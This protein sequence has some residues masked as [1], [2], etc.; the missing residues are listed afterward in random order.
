[1]QHASTRAEHSQTRRRAS[2][3]KTADGRRR[4]IRRWRSGGGARDRRAGASRA[5]DRVLYGVRAGR[6]TCTTSA[7]KIT[8]M[9]PEYLRYLAP[10]SGTTY[11]RHNL[12]LQDTRHKTRTPLALSAIEG[13]LS[14]PAILRSPAALLHS[15]C[16]P[17]SSRASEVRQPRQTQ[18]TLTPA[19]ATLRA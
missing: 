16:S 2:D 6:V 19:S 12:Q 15:S 8:G 11:L 13:N 1:M 3:S 18:Q 17:R 7:T 9:P 5:S 10:T 14:R 4:A